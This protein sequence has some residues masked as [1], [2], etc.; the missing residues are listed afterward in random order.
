MGLHALTEADLAAV[1][2]ATPDLAPLA[3]RVGEQFTT[4]QLVPSEGVAIDESTQTDA[5]VF[6]VLVFAISDWSMVNGVARG[7]ASS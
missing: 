2:R 1:A 7:R 4:Y 5:P 3:V 6:F